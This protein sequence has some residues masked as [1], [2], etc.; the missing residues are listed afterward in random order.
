MRNTFTLSGRRSSVQA[1][2]TLIELIIVI[3]VIGILAAVA[4]PRFGTVTTKANEAQLK[5]VQGALKTAWAVAYG[6]KGGEPTIDEVLKQ[7]DPAC[8]TAGG[9]KCSNLTVTFKKADGTAI[10]GLTD[11]VTDASLITV[12]R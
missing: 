2:F 4:L 11:L 6:S 10:T 9:Y 12:A 3:V 1:G 5:A 7:V 8:E